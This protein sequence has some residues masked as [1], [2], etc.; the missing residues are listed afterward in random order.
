MR[1]E[2]MNIVVGVITPTFVEITDYFNI[3]LGYSTIK[4]EP[5]IYRVEDLV[6]D[7]FMK[8]GRHSSDIRGLWL[9]D[10]KVVGL[11]VNIAIDWH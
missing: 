10:K 6:F 11:L 9:L 4:I 1:Y 3:E 2:D 7:N 8:N 5:Y